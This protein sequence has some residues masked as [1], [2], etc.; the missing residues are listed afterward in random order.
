MKLSKRLQAVANMITPGLPVVDVGTDHGYI[1]IY[2]VEEGLSPRAVASDVNK[3]PLASAV[4]N[5]AAHGLADKIRPVL[6]DGVPKEPLE[7]A[8]VIAGMGG[9]LM[10]RILREAGPFL[11]GYSEMILE[12]QSDLMPFRETLLD[13]SLRIV[14]EEM[15]FEAGKFYPVIRVVPEGA[16]EIKNGKTEMAT[17]AETAQPMTA[18]AEAEKDALCGDSAKTRSG[19]S[20]AALTYGPVL[21][22][23][24]HPVL[25]A[26]AQ[27]QRD[28]HA[29]VLEKLRASG[30]PE[31]HERLQTVA[32]DLEAAEEVL[33]LYEMS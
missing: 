7:G 3:G 9:M 14:D 4:E 2:R 23:K 6:A 16:T 31:S 1:P 24:R 32:A 12:P 29:K 22:A 10:S 25:K 21:M 19:L 5:I 15:V 26:Y 27:K 20:R 33:A 13:L 17:G 11:K 8:L 30:M 18:D 28:M